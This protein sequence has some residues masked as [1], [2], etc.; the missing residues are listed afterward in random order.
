M[1]LNW[2]L[3]LLSGLFAIPALTLVPNGQQEAFAQVGFAQTMESC[4]NAGPGYTQEF[5][6][7]DALNLPRRTSRSRADEVYLHR[8]EEGRAHRD[9]SLPV[10]VRDAQQLLRVAGP[11]R[12]PPC[13]R[14]SPIESAG[15]HLV[16]GKPAAL[17]Q[18]AFK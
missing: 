11:P 3:V 7:I 4:G 13:P 5:M 1:K 8:G 10:F 14:R 17:R 18:S 16:C 6:C 12:I 9:H 2:P 15:A